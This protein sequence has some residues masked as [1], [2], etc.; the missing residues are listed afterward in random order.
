MTWRIR[1]VGVMAVVVACVVCLLLVEPASW[2]DMSTTAQLACLGGGGTT[3]FVDGVQ[4]C[5]WID[6]ACKY[7]YNCSGWP[8]ACGTWFGDDV[9]EMWPPKA[10]SL[11][12]PGKTDIFETFNYICYWRYECDE[13]CWKNPAHDRWECFNS[14]EQPW[15]HGVTKS[16]PAGDACSPIEE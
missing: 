8:A 14:T 1:T 5:P 10:Q 12:Q 13:W 6:A 4:L 7:R 9:T 16:V 2:C 11:S 3:C 15:P